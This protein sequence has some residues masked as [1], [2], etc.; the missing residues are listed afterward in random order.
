MTMMNN[1]GDDKQQVAGPDDASCIIWA[2]GMFF[3]S[4]FSMQFCII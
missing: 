4:F 3:T 2:Y 1:S